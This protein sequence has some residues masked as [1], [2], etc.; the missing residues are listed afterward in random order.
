VKEERQKQAPERP[1]RVPRTSGVQQQGQNQTERPARS[2]SPVQRAKDTVN[3]E[4]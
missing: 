2:T 1:K 4:Q 3:Q